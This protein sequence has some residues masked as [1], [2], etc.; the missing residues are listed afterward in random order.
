MQLMR[1]LHIDIAGSYDDER[2]EMEERQEAVLWE[3]SA[4]PQEVGEHYYLGGWH[5]GSCECVPDTASRHSSA[6]P[7][8]CMVC[9]RDIIRALPG[10]AWRPIHLAVALT[11]AELRSLT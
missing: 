2:L 6:A 5:G 8:L 9:H 10:A 4:V 1:G 11:S 7:P 3:A